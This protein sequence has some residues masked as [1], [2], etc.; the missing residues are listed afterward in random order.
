[1]AMNPDE[2]RMERLSLIEKAKNGIGIEVVGR[3]STLDWEKLEDGTM[4]LL[5]KKPEGYVY[6]VNEFDRKIIAAA[7]DLAELV[8]AV[9]WVSEDGNAFPD[10][11][12]AICPW[13]GGSMET[14]HINNCLRQAVLKKAGLLEQP[15]RGLAAGEETNNVRE[16][17]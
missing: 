15:L 6:I 5:V 3:R 1:M 11:K 16:E 14:G 17:P 2:N 4:Q 7:P 12:W 10:Q 13:C 9:E 8:L